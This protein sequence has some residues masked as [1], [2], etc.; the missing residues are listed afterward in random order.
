MWLCCKNDLG[1]PPA[2]TDEAYKAATRPKPRPIIERDDLGSPPPKRLRRDTD[3][4]RPAHAPLF[5]AC[6]ASPSSADGSK[7]SLTVSRMPFLWDDSS[8]L[9]VIAE[10]DHVTD[11]ASSCVQAAWEPSTRTRYERGLRLA[12]REAEILLDASFLPMVRDDQL[13]A[14]FARMDGMNWNTIRLSKAAVRAWHAAHNEP[15]IF[16]EK[17]THVASLFWAG[18]KKRA[19]HASSSKMPV[20]IQRLVDYQ[21]CRLGVGSAAGRRDAAFAGFC[22]FGVRR[23]AEGI[24]L[25][26]GEVSFHADGAEFRIPRQKNDPVGKGMVCHIPRLPGLGEACPAR[27]C[28]LWFKE[29]KSSWPSSV[30]GPFFYNTRSTLGV[31]LPI[32]YDS[33]RKTI[34]NFVPSKDI[35]THSFRKGGAHWYRVHAAVSSEAI[36]SQGGWASDATMQQIYTALT[37]E[38][39]RAELFAAARSSAVVI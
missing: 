35:G 39:R 25:M 27:L 8:S 32:S 18:L 15:C 10:R 1:E 13:M 20:A 7:L 37:S 38:E 36:R 16:D 4:V 31:P 24:A 33:V 12:V 17:W 5:R 19:S 3:D 14:V 9:H 11:V 26:I 34:A 28:E 2:S 30:G 23:C 21:R 6:E 29:W 22:F